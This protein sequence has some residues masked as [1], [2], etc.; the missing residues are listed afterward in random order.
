MADEDSRDPGIPQGTGNRMGSLSNSSQSTEMPRNLILQGQ[1]FPDFCIFSSRSHPSNKTLCKTSSYKTDGGATL[2]SEAWTRPQA[3]PPAPTTPST[4]PSVE[5]GPKPQ[6]WGPGHPE[7][8]AARQG[9]LLLKTPG[10]RGRFLRP[11][12][13]RSP[14]GPGP[15]P[16]GAVSCAG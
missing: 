14:P 10:G 2:L 13:L 5:L 1:R 8:E 6:P 12:R 15:R 9:G 4:G 3:P 16:H 7:A 11:G